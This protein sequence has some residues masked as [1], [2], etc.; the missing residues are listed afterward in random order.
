MWIISDQVQIGHAV[1]ILREERER[2]E[3][4]EKGDGG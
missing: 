3:R 1:I 2:S 4:R